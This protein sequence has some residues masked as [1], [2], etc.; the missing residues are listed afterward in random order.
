MEQIKNAEIVDDNLQPVSNELLPTTDG[1][2]SADGLTSIKATTDVFSLKQ[3][4]LEAYY[5]GHDSIISKIKKNPN[6]DSIETLITV[7]M[8][9]LLGETDN[10]KGNELIF[11]QDGKLHDASTISVKRAE[12]LDTVSKVLMRK[13]DLMAKSGDVDLDSPVFQLFQT[14]CFD[15]LKESMMN[16]KFDDEMKQ[17]IISKWGE[18][19]SDWKDELASRLKRL[20]SN[21]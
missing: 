7:V 13:R 18:N 6:G 8:E 10:L 21:G 2:N 3:E 20:K 4:L 17:V 14:I 9:E 19:M 5:K 15:A 16:L 12:I 11:T 1:G